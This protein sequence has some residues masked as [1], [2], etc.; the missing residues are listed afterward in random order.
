MGPKWSWNKNQRMASLLKYTF[1]LLQKVLFPCLTDHKAWISYLNVK[2]KTTNHTV[3]SFEFIKGKHSHMKA[4][5]NQLLKPK[6]YF[7]AGV[8]GAI[9]QNRKTIHEMFLKL[10]H[11]VKIKLG[12]SDMGYWCKKNSSFMILHIHI[13]QLYCVMVL[14]VQECWDYNTVWT[15]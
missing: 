7:F 9:N 8:N 15:C 14:Y 1:W 11:E 10:R 3:I 4:N 13:P 5:S 12:S 6:M 2:P